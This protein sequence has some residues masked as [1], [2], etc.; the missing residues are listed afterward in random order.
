MWWAAVMAAAATAAPSDDAHD[1]IIPTEHGDVQCTLDAGGKVQVCHGIPFAEAPLKELRWKPPQPPAKWTRTKKTTKKGPGCPQLDLVR[2]EYIG[3]EDC[4]FLSVYTPVHC[5]PESPCPVMHWIYGGAW[6]LGSNEEFG[7][8]DGTALAARHGVVIVAAN[9]RLDAL[10]WMALDELAAES[11]EGA[12][13]NYGLLDQEFALR[14]TQRNARAFGGDPRAVTIFGESA[15]GYSVCQHLT[16]PGSNGLFSRAIM[17][18]GSCDGPWL[19]FDEYNSKRWSSYYATKVGCPET[20]DPSARMACLRKKPVY[21]LLEPYTEWFCPIPRPNDPWCNRTLSKRQAR[22][23]DGVRGGEWGGQRNG[24]A[25]ANVPNPRAWPSPRP[26]MAPVVGWAA[27]VDGTQ[28]GLPESP[29]QAILRGAVNTGPSGEKISVIFG[30]NHDE[31]ALFIIGAFLVFPG[32]HIPIE[33]RDIQV[34]ASHVTAYHQPTWNSTLMPSV[35]QAYTNGVYTNAHSAYKLVGM[36]TDFLFVCNTRQ[37]AAALAAH[38]HQVH[39]YVF[40][41]KGPLW[42]D[43]AG[44]P[45]QLESMVDCGVPHA[46]ELFYVFGHG[47]RDAKGRVS[48]LFGGWWTNLAIH[49]D[50]NGPNGTAGDPSTVKW[51]PYSAEAPNVMS[52]DEHP[53]VAS[54][55]PDNSRCEAWDKLPPFE[56]CLRLLGPQDAHHPPECRAL[57]PLCRIRICARKRDYRIKWHQWPDNAHVQTDH[58]ACLGPATYPLQSL[59]LGFQFL[60]PL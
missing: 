30:T 52:I 37:S 21:A 48:A 56:P 28:I 23:A 2:L 36:G 10:G 42:R 33:A 25:T 7:L 55:L 44:L 54:G 43:P 58:S 60:D 19:I 59:V 31:M 8:Y 18:S 20:S 17:E 14:W 6:I 40:D 57:G 13:G 3:N 49:G 39:V 46:S 24:G 22:T 15:G 9:Y 4:M 35:V 45:C 27:T 5:T 29:Y 38:G 41:F 51:P 16:R 1:P 34:A 53:S 47:D 11:P 26:P 12:S 50:P 32:V